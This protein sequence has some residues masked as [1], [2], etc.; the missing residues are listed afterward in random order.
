MSIAVD[1]M[2]AEMGVDEVAAG[3]ALA[4]EWIPEAAR[5][6]LVGQIQALQPALAQQRLTDHPR[7]ELHEAGEVIGMDEKPIQA[8]KGKKDAS[9]VRAVERVRD[10]QS[11]AAVSCGNTGAL[12]A[13]ATLRLRPLEG[14]SKPALTTVWPSRDHYFVLLDAGA[15]P[16][17]KPEHLLHNAILGHHYAQDALGLK[18]PRIGLLSIGTEA[19]KGN[20]LTQQADAL[21]QQ[22]GDE[23]NYVGL[24]EGFQMFQG[25]DQP[26]EVIVTDGFTGN[27]V[28]KSCE[29][30]W[31][32][33]KGYV[34]DEIKAHPV[35]MVGAGLLSG[36][37]KKL[38][39]RLDP[40]Q[41]GG[42]PLLGLRG[43][44]IKAHG[45]SNRFA[46][47]HAI[48]IAHLVVERDMLAHHVRSLEQAQALLQPRDAVA[49][50]AS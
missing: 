34:K 37:L 9:M 8:L 16:Q 14:L 49:Q 6:V 17:A 15:N 43:M 10:G 29:S 38:K 46:I 18:R 1:A 5:I 50:P 42:A 12:M 24:I 39:T 7:V 31:K 13:C 3:V 28:L 20:E 2:G 23:F 4:L 32:M 22:L 45:S 11:Q 48:R 44:V 40:D 47:A 27:V 41:Y 36:M 25:G 33:L 21:L 19:G 30:L 35:R 26:V